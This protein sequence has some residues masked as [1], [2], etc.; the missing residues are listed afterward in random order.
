[1][2]VTGDCQ[3]VGALFQRNRKLVVLSGGPKILSDVMEKRFGP[4]RESNPGA[5][6]D[7][8]I[9]FLCSFRKRIAWNLDQFAK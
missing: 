6:S 5:A 3:V 2:N 7:I 8:A 4:Y 1:M 9:D